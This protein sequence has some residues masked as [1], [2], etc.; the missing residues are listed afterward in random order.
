MSGT[1]LLGGTKDGFQVVL[2]IKTTYRDTVFYPAAGPSS[3]SP[4]RQY[5][6]IR[7]VDPSVKGTRI[8]PHLVFTVVTSDIVETP[9]LTLSGWDDRNPCVCWPA[10]EATGTVYEFL[11]A[12]TEESRHFISGS[13]ITS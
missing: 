5:Y 10:S 2:V 6:S 13:A 11:F 12:Q 8:D 4:L 3:A 9:R 7:F 1:L